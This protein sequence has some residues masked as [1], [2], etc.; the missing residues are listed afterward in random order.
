[1][2]SIIELIVFYQTVFID[3]TMVRL[4]AMQV[5]V[6]QKIQSVEKADVSH[7]RCLNHEE[8]E[9]QTL[10]GKGDYFMCMWSRHIHLLSFTCNK[11]LLK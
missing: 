3:I 9:P 8:A 2:N 11:N 6:M 7:Q 1:M 5:V 4:K 10:K